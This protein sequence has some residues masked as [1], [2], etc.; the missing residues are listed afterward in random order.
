MYVVLSGEKTFTLLPPTD[1]AFLPEG[2][3]PTLRHTIREDHPESEK[4]K[5][6][7]IL[8]SI[9]TNSHSHSHS[10][11]HT[12]R[13]VKRADL[14]TIPSNPEEK[15]LWIPVDVDAPEAI[16]QHQEL[17]AHIHPLRCT[18]RAGE[19]LYIPALW[20]HQVSQSRLTVSINFWYE[21]KFDFR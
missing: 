11:S 3:Y 5:E 10:H 20:Y 13:R 6:E 21:M 9:S 14:G 17:F 7:S 15:L 2:V 12:R 4:G 19:T 1:A 16:Q 8:T 18:V